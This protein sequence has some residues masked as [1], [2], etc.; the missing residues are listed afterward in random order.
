[1]TPCE[2]LTALV[3][4]LDFQTGQF[5]LG[6]SS[7][8]AARDIRPI[9]DLDVGVTTRYWF[10]LHASGMWG[11]WTTDPE[12]PRPC[13]PP[14][15]TREVAGV[16]VHVFCQWRKWNADE[17]EFNDFNLVFREGVQ[18]VSDLPVIKLPI[19]LRQKIDA[20]TNCMRDHEAP[21][22]KDISD[23]RAIAEWLR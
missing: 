21:R 1:M 12:G 15:L 3:R 19:L 4:E 7:A 2:Q 11:V 8:L 5:F 14:Y 17:T 13:D 23:I 22:P 18:V 20:V 10:E 16:E 9:G 6:G